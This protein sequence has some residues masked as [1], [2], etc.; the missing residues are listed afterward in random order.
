M[1]QFNNTQQPQYYNNY[2]E[3]FLVI[4][5]FIT[6]II[7][8]KEPFAEQSLKQWI[9]LTILSAVTVINLG[10]FLLPKPKR[11]EFVPLYPY[12][13]TYA[14]SCLMWLVV[15]LAIGWRDVLISDWKGTLLTVSCIVFGILMIVIGSF[16]HVFIRTMTMHDMIIADYRQSH[17]KEP[18]NIWYGK[19]PEQA[20][21]YT[22]PRYVYD[23]GYESE[24]PL[25]QG[26]QV[27]GYRISPTLV[28]HSAT[29]KYDYSPEFLSA[30]M[31]KFRG[32]LLTSDDVEVLKR[33]WDTVSKMH[34]AIGESPLPTPYFWYTDNGEIKSTHYREDYTESDPEASAVILKR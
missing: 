5:S 17:H 10:L 28:I 34:T 31:I 21:G 20:G 14:F 30:F 16:V 26:G 23:N 8:L 1:E 15:S 25:S 12:E 33:N 19:L 22:R 24:T 32:K 4:G 18:E 29:C 11:S 13:K 7:Y 27:I 3:L 2:R 9:Y 6:M